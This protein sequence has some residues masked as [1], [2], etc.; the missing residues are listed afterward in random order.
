MAVARP[1]LGLVSL[2]IVAAGVLFQFFIILSG[3]ANVTPFNKTYFLQV[4]TSNTDATRNPTR[5]T[6]F[7]I[8]GVVNGLNG[9]CGA[10]VPALPFSPA[11]NFGGTDGLPAA[12]I[13][14]HRYFYLSRFFWVFFLIALFFAV[15]ALFTGLLAL[16]TRLGAYLSSLNAMIALFFQA[17]AASL[18]T[19][20]FVQGRNAFR[21]NGMSAHVGAYAFGWMW[22]SFFAYFLATIFF[23]IGGSIG[24]D[25]TSSSNGKSMFGRKRSTR[26]RGSFIDSESQRRVKE[27]YE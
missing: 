13:G 20:C 11:R 17:L 22:A 26:S 4:D 7:K 27:E 5:W 6:Y 24:K 19:A 21:A 3:I 8:C 14:T 23:C 10:S 1:I 15:I 12:F 16:C 18:F 9:N 25:S 2:A